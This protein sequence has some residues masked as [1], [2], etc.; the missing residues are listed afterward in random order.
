[1]SRLLGFNEIKHIT[2]PCGKSCYST[3]VAMALGLDPIEVID[4]LKERG[5]EPPYFNNDIL[6]YLVT[7]NIYADRI[8]CSMASLL[9]VGK[10][11]LV[12]VPSK[13]NPVSFHSIVVCSNEDREFLILDPN[14]GSDGRYAHRDFEENKII[15]LQTHALYEC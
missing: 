9:V 4:E 11:H 12:C 8:D 3:C 5:C 7:K 6:K 14:K 1:M 2:Q 15:F 13:A 10:T